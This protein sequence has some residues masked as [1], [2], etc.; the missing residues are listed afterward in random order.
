MFSHLLILRGLPLGQHRFVL[1]LQQEVRG[2]H[3]WQQH[4]GPRG[5]GLCLPR[6]SRSWSSVGRLDGKLRE[7]R[8]T[9]VQPGPGQAPGNALP[10][11]ALGLRDLRGSLGTGGLRVPHH[12]VLRGTPPHLALGTLLTGHWGTLLTGRWGT[13][14]TG[15]WGPSLLGTRIP[16]YWALGALPH[17][18]LKAPHHWV[19][20]PL[21]GLTVSFSCPQPPSMQPGYLVSAAGSSDRRE[22]GG[23]PSAGSIY[24]SLPWARVRKGLE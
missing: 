8:L 17:W 2:G 11:R 19:L 21:T 20:G 14:L 18:A 10:G 24:V 5:S 6:R 1:F 12:Q 22:R 15:C 23:G 3:Q 4:P 13:L 7:G 16:S 9:A